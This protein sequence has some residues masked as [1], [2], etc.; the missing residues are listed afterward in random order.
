MFSR[1]NR[2]L[3][4]SECQKIQAKMAQK[5]I[6][7]MVSTNNFVKFS[8]GHWIG[9]QIQIYFIEEISLST[10]LEIKIRQI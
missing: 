10:N 6:F 3:I 7:F 4:D 1:F 5:H 9:Y 8:I 2:Q